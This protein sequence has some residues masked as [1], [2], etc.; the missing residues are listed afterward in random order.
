MRRAGPTKNKLVLLVLLAAGIASLAAA[1]RAAS[2]PSGA[3][4]ACSTSESGYLTA[5]LS[6]GVECLH[7]GEFCKTGNAEYHQYGFDCPAGRLE[8][9]APAPAPAPAPTTTA[10]APAPPPV[11]TTT[12]VAT[13]AAAKCS[14]GYISANLPWGH[15]C[16]RTGEF[17][18]IGNRAYIRFGFT[19]PR[20][21]TYGGGEV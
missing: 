13:T 20:R 16:L 11:V 10:A 17:C 21:G 3:F 9:Y 1:P 2:A 18:K 14:A 6:W 12:A 7:D 5:T 19:V 8:T 4:K 15:K